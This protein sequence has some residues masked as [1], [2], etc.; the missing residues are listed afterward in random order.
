MKLKKDDRVVTPHGAGSFSGHIDQPMSN[1]PRYGIILDENIFSYPV[2][3]FRKE[4]IRKIF[5][6]K[7]QQSL[8][9]NAEYPQMLAYDEKRKYI[10]QHDLSNAVAKLLDGRPKAYF[11][12]IINDKNALEIGKEVEEQDW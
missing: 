6:L 4:A 5:I 12:S 8:S 9:T 7:V 2:V 11:E 1:N 10:F 3:Y